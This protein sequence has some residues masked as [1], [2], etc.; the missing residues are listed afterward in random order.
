M[1]KFLHFPWNMLKTTFRLP[2]KRII[3]NN[4]C[5]KSKLQI[6]LML[7]NFNFLNVSMKPVKIQV[8]IFPFSV[9]MLKTT[10]KLKGNS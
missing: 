10:S 6:K 3:F 2:Q 4:I 5:N 8:S 7:L 9:R 1:F